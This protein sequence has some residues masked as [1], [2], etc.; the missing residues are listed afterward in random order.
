MKDK[1]HYQTKADSV[2]M[3]L[4]AMYEEY[5]YKRFKMSKF[6]EY[7]LYLD[8]RNFLNTEHVITFNDING[9]LMALKPDVTLSIAKNV[10]IST[11]T[12]NKLYYKENVYRVDKNSKKYKEI[13]Q[14]GVEAIGSIDNYTTLEVILLALK[15]MSEVDSDFILEL[16]SVSYVIGLLDSLAITDN[17]LRHLLIECVSSKNTHD[18]V[19]LCREYNIEKEKCDKLITLTNISGSYGDCIDKAKMLAEGDNMIDALCELESI[20]KGL[21]SSIYANK[22]RLDFS[23]VRDSDYYNGI[24]FQGYVARCPRVI[25]SGGRYDKLFDKLCKT[26]NAIGFALY[27]DEISTYYSSAPEYD[28]D[29]LII[30]DETEDIC[31]VR[32]IVEGFIDSGKSI[33]CEK[34]VPKDITCLNIVTLSNGILTEVK[35]V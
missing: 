24:A 22:I 1:I 4:R 26:T 18:I 25:L 6:E 21:S 19:A 28:V 30:Y 23:T 9:K 32:G 5:G 14:M 27:L 33:R 3:S 15:T 13:S 12:F 35:N 34:V 2:S 10:K 29:V 17:T 8:N 7:Q 20:Y 31:S 16:S 11:D